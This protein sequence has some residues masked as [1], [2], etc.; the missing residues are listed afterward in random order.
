MAER[1]FCGCG[2]KVPGPAWGT[3]HGMNKWG[4]KITELLDFLQAE[5]ES[6][7]DP[8]DVAVLSMVI[9][10]GSHLRAEL[11]EIIHGLPKKMSV[12][13]RIE[14]RSNLQDEVM[15]WQKASNK[16]IR[17]VHAD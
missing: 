16:L 5:S 6:E 8:G 15:G 9:E 4:Q 14:V 11:G 3:A 7:L 1:C 10:T 12:G 2:K 13:Y 17:A